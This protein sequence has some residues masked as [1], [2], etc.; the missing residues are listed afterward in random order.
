MHHDW[1]SICYL[2]EA[3]STTIT[4]LCFVFLF[5]W[6]GKNDFYSVAYGNFNTLALALDFLVSCAALS[7]TAVLFIQDIKLE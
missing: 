2:S 7:C 5:D 4:F 1:E 6:D 3:A